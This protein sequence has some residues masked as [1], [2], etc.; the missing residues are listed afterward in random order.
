MHV[1][2]AAGIALTCGVDAVVHLG[3]RDRNRLALEG[4]IRGAAGLG[5]SSLLLSRGQ[6]LPETLRGK[7]KGVFDTEP[8]QLFELARGLGDE[9]DELGGKGFFF[10]TPVTVMRPAE[11]WQ[12]LKVKERIDA[13]AQFLQTRPCLNIEML[14][15]YM[16]GIVSLKL[17]HRSSFIVEIPVPTSPEFVQETKRAHP[18]V[19]IP[20]Q[21]VRQVSSSPDPVSGGIDIASQ[22]LSLVAAIPGV[23][24]VNLLYD[25]DP[26]VV[27]SVVERA[28]VAI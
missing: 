13:G 22:M 27:A 1:L 14:Q 19:R 11:D 15:S 12:A 6:K 10:G 23:S 24:G 4:A 21:L 16:Q 26:G 8:P 18:G 2:A 28:G 7:V 25:G 3:C 9:I 17:S 5:V 20:D